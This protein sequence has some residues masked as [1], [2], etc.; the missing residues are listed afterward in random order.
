MYKKLT[1]NATIGVF[2]VSNSIKRENKE[3]IFLKA[4][5][6]FEDHGYKLKFSDNVF[7]DY[8]G[9]AGSAKQKAEELNNMFKDPSIDLIMCLDGGDSCNTIIDYLD[10]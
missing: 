1:K 4:K 5:K 9:M 7:I 2:G 6:L 8:Y 10:Y 3:S